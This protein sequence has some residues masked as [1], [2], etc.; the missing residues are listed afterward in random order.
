MRQFKFRRTAIVAAL[1]ATAVLAGGGIA[2]AVLT[3]RQGGTAVQ[4]Q[5]QHQTNPFSTASNFYTNV[6]GAVVTVTVPPNAQAMLDVRYS[7]ESSCVGDQGYCSVR[8]VVRD[9]LGNLA[10]LDPQSGSDFAFDSVGGDRRESHAMERTTPY[11]GPGTYTVRAQAR[12]VG[13]ADRF[14]LDDWTL[15]VVAV[16]P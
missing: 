2:A 7:A 9:S 12:V 10:Q 14:R 13:G 5:F 16:T 11:L 3:G 8:L 15:A 4:H 1:A 6:S